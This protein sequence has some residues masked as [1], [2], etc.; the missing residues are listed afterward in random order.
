[1]SNFQETGR[2]IGKTEYLIL[3]T[4]HKANEIL[5][6]Q[7]QADIVAYE[8]LQQRIKEG[9]IKNAEFIRDLMDKNLE[10]EKPFYEYP[11]LKNHF[12]KH[13]QY[14]FWCD[15]SPEMDINFSTIL[16]YFAN[17]ERFFNSPILVKDLN[18]PKFEKGLLIIGGYGNGKT[19]FFLELEN[20]LKLSKQSFKGYTTNDIVTSYEACENEEELK[21][22]KN[23]L[24]KGNRYFDDLCTERDASRY[25]KVNVLKDVIEERYNESKIKPQ[26]T[27]ATMNFHNDNP[28]DINK[29]LELI[30]AKYGGRVFDRVFEMFNII[31]WQ[32]KS[33]RK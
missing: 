6:N 14:K 11:Y 25:G 5:T 1:M 8:Q 17:D 29:A 4:K 30:E 9:E 12:V 18:T 16:L 24:K 2:I 19:S 3:K 13:N 27:F 10:A 31:H 21:E 28:N 26:K 33:L 23:Q 32:G 7:E 15:L 22:F 20:V